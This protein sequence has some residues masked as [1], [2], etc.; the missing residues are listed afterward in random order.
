[1]TSDELSINIFGFAGFLS[2]EEGMLFRNSN[3]LSSLLFSF[4]ETLGGVLVPDGGSFDFM[5]TVGPPVIRKRNKETCLVTRNL[6]SS[7]LWSSQLWT[8]FKQLRIEAWKSQDF[9][10]VWTSDLAILV[11]RSNQLSYEATDVGSWTF[12]R[13]MKHFIY[14]FTRNLFSNKNNFAPFK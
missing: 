10:R 13:Y 4:W 3:S 5:E 12:V 6:F 14:H 2:F 8:Q 9:N 7:K 11:Q 1:M